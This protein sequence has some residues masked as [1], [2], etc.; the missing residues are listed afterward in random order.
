M[1]TISADDLVGISTVNAKPFPFWPAQ[2]MNTLDE[3]HVQSPFPTRRRSSAVSTFPCT[4]DDSDNW[5]VQSLVRIELVSQIP[6][7]WDG[8][9][10]LGIDDSVH[11][12][13]IALIV[14]LYRTLPVRVPVPF[15]CPILGGGMQFEWTCG[16]RHIE[17]ELLDSSTVAFLKEQSDRGEQRMQSGEYALTDIE[18]TCRLLTWL[19]QA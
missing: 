12:A 14:R 18:Q 8:E 6:R 11:N 17:L 9:G 19:I 4:E 3:Q 16:G 15:V 13:A 7:N 1:T 5:I 10:S 2:R